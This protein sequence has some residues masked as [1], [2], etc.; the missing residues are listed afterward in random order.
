MAS[1][2]N[3]VTAT[4]RTPTIPLPGPVMVTWLPPKNET[5]SPPTTAVIIPAIGGISLAIANPNPK[6]S[7]I[8]LTT[9]PEKIFLGSVAKNS[10]LLFF[11][12]LIE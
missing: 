6:G 9:N 1:S 4:N 5:N 2:P 12:G 8:K 11:F 7:A 10:F 3:V